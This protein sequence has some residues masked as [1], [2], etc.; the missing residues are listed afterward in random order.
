VAGYVRCVGIR[1]HK[2]V[3]VAIGANN[4]C[5]TH[6][7]ACYS[8]GNPPGEQPPSFETA[9]RLW[10][11]NVAKLMA[12]INARQVRSLH[13][14]AAAADDA[15][16][17]W[18]P[19]STF[20]NAFLTGY[21]N[22]TEISKPLYDYG[23]AEGQPAWG[24][25]RIYHFAWELTRDFPF[26][27]IYYPGMAEEWQ[28]ASKYGATS[29]AGPMFFA[30]VMSQWRPGSIGADCGYAPVEARSTLLRVLN[31]DR[32]TKQDSIPFVSDVYCKS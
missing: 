8:H 3:I 13:A 6:M 20:T 26:P 23:S 15:E 9:G 19:P 4:S 16:P 14:D 30:G 11:G 12:F 5:S 27:E 25:A 31:A 32:A 22:G 7:T 28:A 2:K 17:A 24:P 29:G 18:E 10:N 1:S 21:N